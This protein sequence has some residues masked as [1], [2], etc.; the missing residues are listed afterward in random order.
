MASFLSIWQITP[1]IKLTCELFEASS[2][3]FTTGIPGI[4]RLNQMRHRTC[5]NGVIPMLTAFPIPIKPET[6]SLS[7]DYAVTNYDHTADN[8]ELTKET[9]TFVSWSEVNPWGDIEK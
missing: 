2:E 3:R 5:T 8:K 9:D 4:D 6:S 7:T 1:C